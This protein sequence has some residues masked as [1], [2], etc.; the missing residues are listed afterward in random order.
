MKVNRKAGNKLCSGNG[1]FN[2]LEKNVFD[3]ILCKREFNFKGRIIFCEE[4]LS[5]EELLEKNCALSKRR[6][7]LSNLSSSTT[8]LDIA[9][10]LSSFGEVQNAYRIKSLKNER[11][12]FGFVT[13]YAAHSAIKAVS[14]GTINI[15]G[16]QIFISEFKKN[17]R[18]KPKG[19]EH[20]PPSSQTLKT[21]KQ[22]TLDTMFPTLK[23][24]TK[25]S[26]CI[27]NRNEPK[28]EGSQNT[29]PTSVQYYTHWS[30]FAHTESNIRYNIN[31]DL[32]PAVHVERR[33]IHLSNNQC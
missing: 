27:V 12:P 11:R 32:R 25:D 24:K 16:E 22:D 3:L 21:N 6:I 14:V 17:E 10:A 26:R 9:Q 2:C 28:Y 4:L 23:S 30:G 19:A 29:K 20:Y 18:L 7:F 5:G 8:D 13:F 15:E 31:F 33:A 1:T